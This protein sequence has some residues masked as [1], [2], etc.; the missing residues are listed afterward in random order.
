MGCLRR[1]NVLVCWR[2]V[3]HSEDW[4]TEGEFLINLLKHF[5]CGSSHCNLF[6]RP[7]QRCCCFCCI[8]VPCCASVRQSLRGTR[9]ERGWEGRA[10][11]K[12]RMMATSCWVSR[13]TQAL[14]AV[15]DERAGHFGRKNGEGSWHWECAVFNL[16][17]GLLLQG[18]DLP[19]YI[20]MFQMLY[21][22]TIFLLVIITIVSYLCN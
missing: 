11:W 10:Q 6:T 15:L 17:S 13:E 19:Y 16:T 14:S 3:Q 7:E 22:L 1:G 20:T 4:S 9:E 18:S 2:S 21:F 5:G 8:R 12:E